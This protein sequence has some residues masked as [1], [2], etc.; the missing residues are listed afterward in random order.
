MQQRHPFSKVIW[1]IDDSLTVRKILEICLRREGFEVKPFCDG[2]EALSS[3]NERDVDIPDLVFVDIGLPKLDGYEVLRLLKARAILSETALVVI[4]RRDG[5]LDLLKGR[6][7]GAA[8]YITKP[9]TL[10]T[11]RGVVREQLHLPAEEDR[12]PGAPGAS[13]AVS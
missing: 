8:A 13:P 3:L 1:I 10:A 9:F 4:S 7:A 5:V 11:V 2:V 6:L 12:T